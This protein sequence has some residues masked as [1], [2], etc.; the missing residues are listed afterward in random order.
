MGSHSCITLQCDY[1]K[2]YQIDPLS[3]EILRI[4]QWFIQLRS[5]D[6]HFKT[7]SYSQMKAMT[8]FHLQ[9]ENYEKPNGNDTC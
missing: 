7:C 4:K 6:S 3:I 2:T 5:H 8:S 1:Y 9:Y